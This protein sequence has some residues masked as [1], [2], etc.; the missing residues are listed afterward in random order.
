[1]RPTLPRGRHA[2]RRAWVKFFDEYRDAV[3]TPIGQR[4]LAL[5]IVAVSAFVANLLFFILLVI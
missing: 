3:Y 1:M 2:R 5:M 4:A